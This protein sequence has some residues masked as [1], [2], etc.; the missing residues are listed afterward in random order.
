MT[1]GLIRT[2]ESG[3]EYDIGSLGEQASPLKIERMAPKEDENNSLSSNFISPS[4]KNFSLKSN[5]LELNSALKLTLKDR[6]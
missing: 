1:L 5:K 3:T 2:K 4:K 6:R